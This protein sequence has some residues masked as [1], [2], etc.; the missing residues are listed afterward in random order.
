MNLTEQPYWHIRNQR[1]NYHWYA[2]LLTTALEPPYN[3]EQETIGN[4]LVCFQGNLTN[5]IYSAVQ[6]FRHMI[7]ERNFTILTDYKPLTFAFRQKTDKMFSTPDNIVADTLSRI[8]EITSSAVNFEALAA[9]QERDKELRSYL[10]NGN[11]GLDMRIILT[12]GSTTAV[13]CD[14]K[15]PT[16]KPFLTKAFRRAAF[17]AIHGLPHPGVRSPVRLMKERYVWPFIDNDWR[18]WACSCV[19]CQQAKI[20]RYVSSAI[21]HFQ[22]P[23]RRLEHIHVDLDVMAYSQGFRYCLTCVDRFSW[24]TEAIPLPDQEAET[25][26]GTGLLQPIGN[27]APA[28]NGLPPSSQRHGRMPTP[29]KNRDQVPPTCPLDRNRLNRLAGHSFCVEGR[30]KIHYSRDGLRRTITTARRIPVEG[31]RHSDSK[32]FDFK[33]V[34]TATHVFVRHDSP[35]TPLQ[36]PYDGLYEVVSRSEKIENSI[37][38]QRQPQG[39]EKAML[40]DDGI[41]VVGTRQN[42][43][44]NSP[45]N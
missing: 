40:D 43:D 39:H 45:H 38:Y 37:A 2:T 28:D 16:A 4:R 27:H 44:P 20:T 26:R 33:D 3:N 23:P 13:Y 31:T 1:Q 19:Q 18:T 12:P 42:P 17:S 34:A 36:M 8:D 10:E 29:I 22:A 24:W 9:S 6:R 14:V 41:V 15:T 5:L 32:I 7:E 35:K 11:T 30:S 21:G 25:V